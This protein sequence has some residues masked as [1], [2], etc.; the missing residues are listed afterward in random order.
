MRFLLALASSR[1]ILMIIEIL[2]TVQV[3]FR[4]HVL[5]PGAR[6]VRMAMGDDGAIHRLRGFPW[7]KPGEVAMAPFLALGGGAVC[8][9]AMP[10]AITHNRAIV[11]AFMASSTCW[12]GPLRPP[13]A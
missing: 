8:A 5:V 4:E 9:M 13:R 10:L 7:D 1:L 11:L 12:P 3:S 2:Y 6:M